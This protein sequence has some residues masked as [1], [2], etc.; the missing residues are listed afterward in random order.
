MNMLKPTLMNY[1][2]NRVNLTFKNTSQ[3]SVK[4]NNNQMHSAKTVNSPNGDFVVS[5]DIYINDVH[6]HLKPFRQFKSA[7]DDF[8]SKHS[9]AQVFI[10]GDSW[11][12]AYQKKN[13]TISKQ[14]AD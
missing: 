3:N 13:E 7:V 9:D 12:G 2:Q 8:R 6:G 4:S 1:M 11:V 10:S 5:R 14:T